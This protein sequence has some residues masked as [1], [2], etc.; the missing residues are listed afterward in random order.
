MSASNT[1]RLDAELQVYETSKGVW[2]KAHRDEFVVIKGIDVLGFYPTF[3]EAYSA[4]AEKFGSRSDF[5]VKRVALNEP[6]FVVF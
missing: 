4:G 6:V 5:L 1:S 3:Q 2:L